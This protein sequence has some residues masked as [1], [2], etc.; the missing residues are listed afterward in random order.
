MFTAIRER[1]IND[2]ITTGYRGKV[3]DYMCWA[4]R[5][6]RMPQTVRREALCWMCDVGRQMGVKGGRSDLTIRLN[7]IFQPLCFCCDFVFCS[8]I[9]GGQNDKQ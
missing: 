9:G 8:P 6:A 3:F 4:G 2:K 7:Y 5:G 1:K